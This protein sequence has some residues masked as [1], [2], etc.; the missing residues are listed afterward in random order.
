M[1]NLT[2]EYCR[3]L[4]CKHGYKR[5]HFPLFCICCIEGK[6]QISK[7]KL[8]AICFMYSLRE[9]Q[10]KVSPTMQK[11]TRMSWFWFDLLSLVLIQGWWVCCGL[12]KGCCARPGADNCTHPHCSLR[13][14]AT[15]YIQSAVVLWPV[16]LGSN[17]SAPSYHS[18]MRYITSI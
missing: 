1:W 6:Q 3:G 11:F 17:F 12:D 7:Q 4:A 18:T 15:T 8:W 13:K 9:Q 16:C 2:L 14:E 5:Q 10:W